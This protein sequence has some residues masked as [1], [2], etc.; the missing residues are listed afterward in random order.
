[1]ERSIEKLARQQAKLKHK[2]YVVTGMNT[3]NYYKKLRDFENDNGIHIVRVKCLKLIYGDLTVPLDIP[4]NIINEGDILHM[5][6]QNTI[7]NIVLG[8]YARKLNVPTATTF[9]GLNAFINHPSLLK[10]M[11]GIP[12]Q[13]FLTTYAL[14]MTNLRITRSPW[15]YFMLRN[16]FHLRNEY[17]PE[18]VDSEWLKNKQITTFNEKYGFDSNST[19]IVLFVGRLEESKGVDKLI[20]TASVVMKKIADVAFV[21]V[22]PGDNTRFAK[23][24]KQLEIDHHVLFTGPIYDEDL[25]MSAFDACSIFVLPSIAYEIFP[26]VF[27]EAWARKKPIV[28]SSVAGIPFII[29]HMKNGLL[30]RAGDIISLADSIN[31]LLEDPSLCNR[32]AEEGCKQVKT[33]EEVAK[34]MLRAYESN[35]R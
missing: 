12:Y 5:H 3:P 27:L 8:S 15:D 35:L 2:V 9:M 32:L 13:H 6:S 16:V 30:V 7:F 14:R 4:K 34:L 24:A 10:R 17:I 18:G 33:T 25:L 29:R 28:A 20:R 26:L 19:R 21:F 31:F 11:F 23:L 1:M 22:G